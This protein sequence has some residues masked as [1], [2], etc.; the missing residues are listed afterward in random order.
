MI[1]KKI[2]DI[3]IVSSFCSVFCGNGSHVK[4]VK[5]PWADSLGSIDISLQRQSEKII[6]FAEQG[7]R[8]DTNST[9]EA[10]AT[11]LNKSKRYKNTLL[12]LLLIH[13][14]SHFANWMSHAN[15]ELTKDSW[16][17]LS[18][19]LRNNGINQNDTVVLNA[20]VKA[21]YKSKPEN[22]HE[23]IIAFIA[24]YND[25]KTAKL[26]GEIIYKNFNN[27]CKKWLLACITRFKE[28]NLDSIT[29]TFLLP[30]YY[31][32]S[33]ANGLIGYYLKWD[34]RYDLLPELKIFRNNLTI[35][36]IKTH[37]KKLLEILDTTIAYLEHKKA[38]NAS[39]GLP[40]N[41]PD[42]L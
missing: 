21:I 25:Y 8:L 7:F 32:D 27:D 15:D 20:I 17:T 31:N 6:F 2:I 26:F 33:V 18:F 28:N 10:I 5:N 14:P 38:E 13:S 39:I 9:L 40:L 12:E 41:W 34:R 4:A 42:E 30:H 36:I 22:V 24:Q 11:I 16:E 3:I 1:L 37:N 29:K 23:Q 35:G 19:A